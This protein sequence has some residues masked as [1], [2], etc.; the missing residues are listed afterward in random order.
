M[1][2]PDRASITLSRGE[3]N[4]MRDRA[5]L[6]MDSPHVD[7]GHLFGRT[8]P[9]RLGLDDVHALLES[10][11]PAFKLEVSDTSLTVRRQDGGMLAELEFQW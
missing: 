6:T 2:I 1:D 4:W 10:G 8:T 5:V 7:I 9:V 3:L 11:E